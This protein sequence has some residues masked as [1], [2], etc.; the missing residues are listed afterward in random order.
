M[1]KLAILGVAAA[2]TVSVAVAEDLKSGPQPGDPVGAYTVEKCAGNPNDNVDVG[3]NLCYRCMLGSKPVVMVFTR[4]A[5]DKLAALVKK[6]DAKLPQHEDQKLSAF[7]NLIGS[8]N[9]DELKTAAKQFGEKN[10]SEHVAI[11]V[12]EDSEN[13]PEDYNINPDAEVTVIIYKDGTVAANHAF[14]PGK[15]DASG[16]KSVIDDTAKILN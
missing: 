12:P 16:I 1:K 15:L 9:A 10:K 3:K 2:L 8:K 11:V 6:L 4:K 13:G 7:V 5:D 14:G